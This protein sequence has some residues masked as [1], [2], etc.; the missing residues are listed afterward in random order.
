MGGVDGRTVR[1]HNHPTIPMDSWKRWTIIPLKHH[2]TLKIKILDARFPPAL[3]AV[4]KE[5]NPGTVDWWFLTVDP[6]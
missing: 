1:G 4:S 5:K 2:C 3:G 6:V